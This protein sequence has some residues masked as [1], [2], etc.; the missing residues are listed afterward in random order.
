MT[1]G[2]DNQPSNEGTKTS[3][4]VLVAHGIGEQRPFQVLDN[5]SRGL[6]Q[7]LPQTEAAKVVHYKSGSGVFDHYIHL[8][9]RNLNLD[10]YELYWAPLAAG[11]AT[12][13][14]IVRW[15]IN[16]AFTPLRIFSYNVP[17]IIHRA[18]ESTDI[19]HEEPQD[20]DIKA[21]IRKKLLVKA[22][23]LIWPLIIASITG[24]FGSIAIR[25]LAVTLRHRFGLANWLNIILS[26]VV[27]GTLTILTLRHPSVPW[28]KVSFQLGRELWRIVY[29]ALVAVAAAAGGAYVV[30]NG[31]NFLKSLWQFLA[32][33]SSPSAW[34]PADWLTV[35][36]FISSMIAFM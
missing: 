32:N 1:S 12:F 18:M 23:T 9:S 2:S 3:H 11:R 6:W 29:I 36:F 7:V 27:L 5:F 19:E 25:V 30:S 35:G 14:G 33:L 24:A 8:E 16:T 26:L 15:I 20:D 4:A 28:F 10:I 22:L 17:L 34:K 13:R 31:S 21:T